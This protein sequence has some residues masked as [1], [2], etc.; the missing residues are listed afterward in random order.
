MNRTSTTQSI[1][2]GIC[3]LTMG[4]CLG[5]PPIEERWSRI[6]I[7]EAPD[8][9]SVAPGQ[10]VPVTVRVRFTYREILTGAIIAELRASDTITAADVGLENQDD[11]LAHA[12]DVDWV[13]QNSTSLGFGARPVTGFD[14]L[15]QEMVITFDSGLVPP[16]ADPLTQPTLPGAGT[17]LFFVVYFGQVDEVELSDGSEIEVVTPT[18]TDQTDYLSVGLE[19]P[20]AV[21]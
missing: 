20:T 10:T 21:P 3:A 18:F 2:A 13:L 17:N 11:P 8:L 7:L 6:E 5:E 1:L 19:I 12:R 15:I 16:T 4:G 9:T 14:H